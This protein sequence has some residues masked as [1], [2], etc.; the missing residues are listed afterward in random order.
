MIKDNTITSI[1]GQKGSGKSFLTKQI[2][3]EY[4]RVIVVDNTQEYDGMEIVVGYRSCIKRLMQASSEKKFRLSLR[5]ES[6]E[7]DLV[8]LS[9]AETIENHLL[10]IE[11]ASRYVS[12]A[13]LPKPIAKLI[14]FGRHKCINQ[15]YLA[16]RATE[17]HRDITANSDIIITFHQHEPRDVKYLTEFMGPRAENAPRLRKYRFIAW[18]NKKKSPDIVLERLK[19]QSA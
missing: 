8:L 9:M 16:R 10:V 17:L 7:E 11:E 4:K 15:I 18:G 3:Q 6:T 12:H 5:A 1:I 2:I 14:R 19:E 13:M